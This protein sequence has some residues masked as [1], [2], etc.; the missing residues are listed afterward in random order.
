[1]FLMGLLCLVSGKLFSQQCYKVSY[2]KN[3]NRISLMS[4]NCVQIFRDDNSNVEMLQEN[5]CEEQLE[6]LVFYP[7]PSNGVFRIETEDSYEEAEVQIYDNKGVLINRFQ[8]EKG[9][10]IDISN[11][12]QGVYLIRVVGNGFVRN[13]VVVRR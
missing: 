3:G 10:E 1:M 8:F 13:G 5:G 2:D 9:K 4:T 7:N 12:S 6:Y 11:N